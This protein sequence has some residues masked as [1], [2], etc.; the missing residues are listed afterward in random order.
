[1]RSVAGR[2]S[3]LIVPTGEAVDW[4][5]LSTVVAE[6]PERITCTR[7]LP[8]RRTLRFVWGTPPRA[9]DL[10]T[11][12]RKRIASPLVPAA[13]AE[14]CPD[15]SPDGKRLV[16]QGHAQDGRAFAFLSER[17]DG[18][19]AVPVVPIAEP[20]MSSEPTWIGDG[21]MFSYDVDTKHV[22][23]FS[24][25]L[26]RVTIVPD[27]TSQH[28]VTLFRAST[29]DAVLV[30]GV[31]DG[32]ETEVTRVELPWLQE[33]E[34]FRVGEPLLDVRPDGEQLYAVGRAN[35]QFANLLAL[36]PRRRR[37][38]RVGRISDQ[39]IRSPIFLD[40]SLSFVS[41]RFNHKLA[42]RRRDGTLGE[43]SRRLDPQARTTV[44]TT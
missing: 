17:P 26:R 41:T 20:T 4:T 25:A 23:V 37:A 11:V 33:G 36:E 8:D 9:E 28:Y 14:G 42:V 31:F 34:R 16:F 1:M 35:G 15:L 43:P 2:E 44:E 39:T 13:Y 21:Q 32:G 29:V 38:R 10:D 30:S 7:L 3:P 6:T 40:E 19:D 27:A 18:T 5:A 22:G 12:T 24:T